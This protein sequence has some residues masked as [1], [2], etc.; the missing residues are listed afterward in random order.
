V[1]GLIFRL[2]AIV[3]CGGGGGLVAWLIV[4]SLGG[5]GVGA[6]IAGAILGMVVATLLW[7]GGV[8]LVRALR[9]DRGD[10]TNA[11]DRGRL[12]R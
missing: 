1:L 5:Y 7:V 9:L 2:L 4:S 10:T 8:A 11:A 6:A 3:V 12:G